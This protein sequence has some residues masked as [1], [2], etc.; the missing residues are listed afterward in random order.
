MFSDCAC[1]NVRISST[2]RE[3]K[4]KMKSSA[5]QTDP[6]LF[7][8]VEMEVQTGSGTD[9]LQ[10]EVNKRDENQSL[11]E[12]IL[13]LSKRD[14]KWVENAILSGFVSV[15]FEVCYDPD[16]K[17]P[18]ETIVSLLLYKQDVGVQT[19]CASDRDEGKESISYDE[20]KL[21]RFLAS[22]SPSIEKFLGY[23]LQ[24]RAFEGY[25]LFSSNI[26]EDIH[27]WKVLSVDLAKY[28]VI[29]PD[30]SSAKHRPGKI[31]RCMLTRTKERVYD[32]EFEDGNIIQ[33]VREEHI[34]ML[35]DGKLTERKLAMKG[36]V[37]YQEGIRV[38]ARVQFKSGNVKY[39]PGRI[40]KFGRGSVYD[41]ECEGGK[42]ISGLTSDDLLV[43]VEVNQSVEARRPKMIPLQATGI[44]WNSTGSSVAVSYGRQDLTGW[45]D[46][47]GAVCIWNVFGKSF[48][49][50]EPDYVL[51]HST[52]LMCVQF[53]PENPSMIAA[54]SYNGE[55]LCWDLN[56]PD[57]VWA[58]SSSSEY[59]HQEPI[60]NLRW[61][62]DPFHRSWLLFSV[63][64]DGKLLQWE[65]AANG[66]RYPVKG[67]SLNNGK[68]G[69][70]YV[71]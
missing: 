1:S 40:I 71:V 15:D 43:G 11:R 41:V 67:H 4:G 39:L 45:C 7:D 12:N 50:M 54:A 53:H 18:A 6:E 70:R 56:V 69:K 33:N 42:K 5:A 34:R 64:L 23:N 2:W 37:R 36:N 66:F 8:F 25:E 35:E 31:V 65:A 21:S 58:M 46:F 55:V 47:P 59:T 51:D 19:I 62:F 22:V 13:L 57:S 38:H 16:F 61:I 17:L 20:R 49:S 32:I 24:S 44:S 9:F 27:L 30:W 26:G 10:N 29:L 14:E 3:N 60:L 48:N 63:G 28:H 52:C 68:V